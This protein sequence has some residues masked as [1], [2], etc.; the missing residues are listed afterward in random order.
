MKS[1]FFIILISCG[2]SQKINYELFESG[3]RGNDYKIWIYFTDKN[4]SELINISEETKQRRTQTSI[5]EQ[6]KPSNTKQTDT[7]HTRKRKQTH[8]NTHTRV[9]GEHPTLC[10][11]GCALFAPKQQQNHTNFD[12]SK[13]HI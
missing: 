10:L 2:L 3:K 9:N 7:K 6:T 11:K 8:T 1:L 13:N 12:P 4:G 5:P